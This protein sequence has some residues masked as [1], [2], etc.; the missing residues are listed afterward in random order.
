MV[1]SSGEAASLESIR[2]MWR[3]A[4]VFKS[5]KDVSRSTAVWKRTVV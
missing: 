2:E 1:A 4:E 3:S 5:S